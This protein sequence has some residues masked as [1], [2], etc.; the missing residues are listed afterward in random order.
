MMNYIHKYFMEQGMIQAKLEGW[1]LDRRAVNL[2]E[3]FG[4][5]EIKKNCMFPGITV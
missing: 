3:S 5:K 1:Q 2:Y 4:Y